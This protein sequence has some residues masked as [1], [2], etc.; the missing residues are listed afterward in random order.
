MSKDNKPIIT[1]IISLTA[2]AITACAW[3]VSE[4]K[5]HKV[6]IE[7]IKKYHGEAIDRIYKKLTKI[8]EKI[9]KLKE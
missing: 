2:S 3:A 5:S 4:V 7:N 9:D 1:L 8:D 6:E